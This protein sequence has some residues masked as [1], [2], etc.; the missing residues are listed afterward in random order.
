MTAGNG[1]SK[2]PA[3]SKTMN[4]KEQ[5]IRCLAILTLIPV[6]RLILQQRKALNKGTFMN[7]TVHVL[8]NQWFL[9]ETRPM[10]LSE[11]QRFLT[12]QEGNMLRAEQFMVGIHPGNIRSGYCD[13][14][15][16]THLPRE[17]EREKSVWIWCKFGP[18]NFIFIHEDGEEVLCVWMIK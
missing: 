7:L 12:A 18:H 14:N 10:F 15:K 17:R 2:I 4:Q 1:H 11:S 16:H 5:R 13:T 3:E 9:S 6:H 8:P